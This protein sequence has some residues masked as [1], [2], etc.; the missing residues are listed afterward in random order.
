MDTVPLWVQL[1]ALV[2]LILVSAFFSI[3]ETALMALNRHRVKHLARRGSRGAQITLW[4][5][6]HTDRML[7][8]ILI[9]NT[10]LNAMTTALVTAL[11]EAARQLAQV[12]LKA[13]AHR[14][15]HVRLEF[16]VDEVLEVRQAVL[17][18]HLVA[19][20]AVVAIR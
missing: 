18:R 14:P 7:S 3:S 4:L 9:A 16:G 6:D 12:Q 20:G 10:L 2:T 1:L 11:E 15:Y 13:A 19:V 8:L 17:G 5:L